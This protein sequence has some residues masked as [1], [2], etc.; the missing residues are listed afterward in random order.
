MTAL[1]LFLLWF[2]VISQTFQEL[3]WLTPLCAFLL[4]SFYCTA[5]LFSLCGS[6]SLNLLQHSDNIVNL[7][8]FGHA[9]ASLSLC[10]T[11]IS[12]IPTVMLSAEMFSALVIAFKSSSMPLIISSFLFSSGVVM[13]YRPFFSLSPLWYP[14]YSRSWKHCIQRQTTCA[15]PLHTGISPLEL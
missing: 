6:D 13:P 5:F 10:I 12:S 2:S 9:V 11:I 4:R 8:R 1:L 15:V 7:F 14:V 3:S